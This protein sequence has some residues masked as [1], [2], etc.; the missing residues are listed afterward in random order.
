MTLRIEAKHFHLEL[1]DENVQVR[2]TVHRDARHILPEVALNLIDERGFLVFQYFRSGC[3]GMSLTYSR[4]S[5]YDLLEHCIPDLTSSA[6]R[7][8]IER[9]L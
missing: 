2:V 5:I 4:I 6:F 9:E 7:K 1:T 3:S 8:V